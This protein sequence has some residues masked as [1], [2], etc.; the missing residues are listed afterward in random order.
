MEGRKT[1]QTLLAYFSAKKVADFGKSN[2]RN[3]KVCSDC[4]ANVL[5]EMSK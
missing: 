2:F 4:N 5:I 1:N 3:L